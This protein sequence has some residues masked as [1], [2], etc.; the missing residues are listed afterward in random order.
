MWHIVGAQEMLL[1]KGVNVYKVDFAGNELSW[2][3]AK[4]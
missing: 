1:H 2:E 3:G 4:I